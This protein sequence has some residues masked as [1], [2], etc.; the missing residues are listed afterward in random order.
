VS[1]EIENKVALVIMAHPDDAEFSCAG[2]V[3]KWVR[4]GW[5]VYYVVCTEAGSGGPDEATEVGAQARRL[6]SETRREEQQAAARVLGLAGVVFLD[7]RDGELQPTLGFRREVVRLLRTYR[8]HRVV[9]QSPE[10]SW[11]PQMYIGAYHPDHRACGEGVISAIYPAS[12]NPWD[13][14]ELLE[15]EGLSPHKVRELYVVGAPTLNHWVDISE[16]MDLK[17]EALLAHAS[18]FVGRVDEVVK[19]VREQRATI[20]QKYGVAYAE[21]FHLALNR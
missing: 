21:E 7:H 12:Q 19:R 2:S 3:A 10:R 18:Q 6:V 16:T 1:N 4:E 13:F 20:G 11:T 15:T 9:C 14:P 17:I 5:Q 8:P